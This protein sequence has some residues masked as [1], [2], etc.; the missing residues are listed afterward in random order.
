MQYSNPR[1]FATIPD[2]PSGRHRTLAQFAIETHPTRGQRGTRS[3]KDPKTGR[4]SKPKTLTYARKA[5]IVDGEDGHTYILEHTGTHLRVMQGNMQFEQETISP[6]DPQYAGLVALFDQLTVGECFQAAMIET[7]VEMTDG[8]PLPAPDAPRRSLA[9]VADAI[10]DAAR[11][12]QGQITK[13]RIEAETHTRLRPTQ[14]QA[15]PVGFFAQEQ[16]VLFR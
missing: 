5:R 3:T 11:H 15:A 1:L 12:T 9:D 2:W 7:L 6:N 8:L 16:G 4:M 10:T 14:V 13:A